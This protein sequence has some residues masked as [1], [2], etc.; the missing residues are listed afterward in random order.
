MTKKLTAAQVIVEYLIAENVPYVLGIFGHG[1]VQLGEALKEREKEITFIPVKN[2]Q[3]AVHMAAAYAKVTG[4]P[5]AVTTSIGPGATNLVTGAAAARVNRLP[6]L[7]LPGDSFTDSVGPVLQQVENNNAVEERA[8]DT[9]K[10]VSAYWVRINKAR[11]LQKRLPEAFDA[12]LRPGERG[13]ATLCLPMDVQAEAWDFDMEMLLRP[14]DK[15]WERVSPDARA[16]KR[17]AQLIRGAKRPFIIAGGGT[18]VSE[19]WDEVVELAELVGIPV[20]ATQ[21]GNGTMLHDHPLNVF[22]VGPIG[23]TCGNI[24]ASKA[25]VIIGIGTR[26]SDFTTSS[27]TLFGRDAQFI[28]INISHFDIGKE[29][30]VK[31]F[32][33]AARGLGMLLKELKKEKLPT[34]RN[35]RQEIKTLQTKWIAGTDTLRAVES[36]PMAQSAIVG[37]VN[38]FCDERDVAVAAAGSLPRDLLQLWRTQDPTR[39]GYHME[40]GYSTMGYEIAGAIGVKLADPSRTVYSMVGDG[41]FLMASQDI[42]TAVQERMPITVVLFDSGGHRSIRGTQEGNG[43]QVFGTEY[44]M[45]NPKTGRLSG[46]DIPIDFVKIAEGYGAKALRAGTRE[47]LLA[48]LKEAKG[49]TDRPT[50]IHVPTHRTG[51]E[52]R[53]VYGQDDTGKWWDVP[54]PEVSKREVLRKQRR[55][56]EQD[57]K[58][59]VIR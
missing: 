37:V 34:R 9:L 15:D 17:A 38:D 40:Y 55:R 59:Q 51:Y 4:Q 12:M 18:I 1:N 10:P 43:M 25:D 26:Y 28:N 32:G 22:S 45:R 23:S 48:A 36:S 44:K 5:L 42:V 16:V 29:R 52:D 47:E 49:T 8:N 13:P 27:E 46:K 11:Q 57:K 54:R 50:V 39:R 33:D 20:A 19:A 3:N 31:M 2:E 35:Y 21:A 56:Y 7:L 53:F 14:R 6:V 58:R 24:L 30:A 41:S